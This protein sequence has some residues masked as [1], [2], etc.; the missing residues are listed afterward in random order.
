MQSESI[1]KSWDPF[2]LELLDVFQAQLLS[3]L[4]PFHES[5]PNETNIFSMSFT[6]TGSSWI[7]EC[8]RFG[9]F[10]PRGHAGPRRLAICCWF[11]ELVRGNLGM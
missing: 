8:L 6:G 5:A 9:A 7:L 1:S 10:S 2:L 4:T 3:L 11:P